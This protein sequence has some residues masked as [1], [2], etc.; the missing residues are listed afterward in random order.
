MPESR[1]AE[2]IEEWYSAMKQHAGQQERAEAE[3]TM[4]QPLDAPVKRGVRVPVVNEVSYAPNSLAE[5][6]RELAAASLHQVIEGAQQ[7]EGGGKLPVAMIFTDRDL[8]Q[9]LLKAI[10]G[11]FWEAHPVEHYFVDE[12]DTVP[13]VNAIIVARPVAPRLHQVTAFI[14]KHNAKY[15]QRTYTCAWVPAKSLVC[16]KA[17]FDIY[18]RSKRVT[19][20]S[21]QIDLSPIDEDLLTM[22]IPHATKEVLTKKE[23]GAVESTARSLARLE[24][25][26]GLTPRCQ[27]KG[28]QAC[29]FLE[30]LYSLRGEAGLCSEPLEEEDALP[31]SLCDRLVVIDRSIDLV[32]PLLTQ[33]TYGGLIDEILGGTHEA[34]QTVYDEP[35]LD[36]QSEKPVRIH[37]D[38][39][40]FLWMQVTPTP[41]HCD[42]LL[43]PTPPHCDADERYVLQRCRTPPQRE[44]PRP[45]Q[46]EERVP[47]E[48][49]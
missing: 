16:E 9:H 7:T 18:G 14:N 12:V 30:I 33:L 35:I 29:R 20:T 3:P 26:L 36:L 37:F 15:S 45:H 43:T 6:V 22:G 23:E 49:G 17:L 40:D 28:E 21:L 38:D 13:D 2:E 24:E 34:S 11:D 42:A 19:S 39:S 10:S 5:V 47:G 25:V 32:T 8:Q 41:P 1:S 31:E 48:Q 4:D 27:A 44:M 46:H